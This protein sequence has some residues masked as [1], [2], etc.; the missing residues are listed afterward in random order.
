[1]NDIDMDD[2]LRKEIIH[3]GSIDLKEFDVNMYRDKRYARNPQTRPPL[4]R[5]LLMNLNQ[6]ILIDSILVNDSKLIYKEIDMKSEKPGEIFISDI[7]LRGYNLTNML[8]ENDR[9]TVLNVN[10]DGK[11]MGKSD[12]NLS[13]YFPMYPDSTAFWL[14]GKTEE[15]EMVNLNSMTENLLGIGIKGGKGS[16]EIPLI[17]ANDSIA[18]GTVMFRYKKL[19]LALYSRKKDQLNSGMFSPLVDFFIND[20]VVRTNNPKFAKKA[21]QGIV[22]FQRD[23]QKGIVN[24]AWKGILSGLISTIGINNKN[25]R[26]ER[27]NLK[28][29]PK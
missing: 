20:L 9:E 25:Q 12:M 6:K 2:L 1:M 5:E 29:S 28:S 13:I 23:P 16:V 26:Q 22:Y 18:R 14:T 7:N 15:I 3:C 10:L 19:K 8:K 4:I 21:K 17:I 27:K 11:I 24:Y